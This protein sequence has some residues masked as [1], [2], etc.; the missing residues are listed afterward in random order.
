MRNRFNEYKSNVAIVSEGRLYTYEDLD[1][2]I[3]RVLNKI[4]KENITSGETIFLLSDYSFKA[5]AWLLALYEN[6]NIVVPIT[7]VVEKEISEKINEV[8]VDA[9][10]NLRLD[11]ISKIKKNRV[12]HNIIKKLNSENKSGLIIFSSGS[13]GKPKAMIHDMDNL[14]SVYLNKRIRKITFMVFL[15]FDHIGGINTLFNCL[16]TG[17]TV[18]IPTKREPEEVISLI[19]NYKV[20]ILPT[21]PTFLNLM[22]M[23]GVLDKYDT[24]SLRMITYGTEIMPDSL[25]NRLKKSFN[26][27]K[28]LQTFGTSETGIMKSSSKSSSSTFIKLDDPDQEY[29]IVKGE[30]WLRSKTQVLGYMNHSMESFTDDGWF[31]TGDLVEQDGE[32]IKIKGRLKEVIN[33]GGEKV[34]PAEVENVLMSHPYVKDCTVH[35]AINPITGQTVIAN[36]MVKLG[37][38]KKIIRKELKS[39]CKDNLEGYKVPTKF[40][41]VESNEYTDRFKKVRV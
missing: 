4:K 16:S 36:V 22:L 29:K 24:S 18:V 1:L 37:L 2:E 23:S 5:I 32:Y 41:F 9:V 21:S 25:L 30:L 31:M 38:D 33:V 27:V 26:R 7:S 35:G 28:F 34:L 15:M 11:T 6:K 20:Q 40:K 8:T 39:F 10:V 19:D 14:V 17:A 12:R 13:T 3:S